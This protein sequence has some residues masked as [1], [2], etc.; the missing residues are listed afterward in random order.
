M[1]KISRKS[2][3]NREAQFTKLSVFHAKN[4]YFVLI[5]IKM[6]FMEFKFEHTR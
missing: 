4:Q 5:A 3:E 1:V 2:L 6:L